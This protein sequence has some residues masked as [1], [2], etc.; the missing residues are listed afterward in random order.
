MDYLRN[1]YSQRV[2]LYLG[3][4]R[5]RFQEMMVREIERWT[6]TYSNGFN[7]GCPG[8]ESG[9]NNV[10]PMLMWPM[11]IFHKADI[12]RL[13]VT[14]LTTTLFAVVVLKSLVNV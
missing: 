8:A 3:S 13:Q 10:A 9:H 6:R 5:R 7:S 11:R 2:K 4:E 12:C 14:Q 1:A